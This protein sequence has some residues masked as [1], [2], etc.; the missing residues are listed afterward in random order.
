MPVTLFKDYSQSINE[1]VDPR[2]LKTN[3]KNMSVGQLAR[4]FKSR[5]YKFYGYIET[6]RRSNG[7]DYIGLSSAIPADIMEL[8]KKYYGTF[9]NIV[10]DTYLSSVPDLY[11]LHTN[12]YGGDVESKDIKDLIHDNTKREKVT[13]ATNKDAS[14]K[15]FVLFNTEEKYFYFMSG[16]KYDSGHCAWV[17]L[18]VRVRRDGVDE[19]RKELEA[20][21]D[22]VEAVLAPEREAAEEKSRQEREKARLK[23]IA[24]KE[25]EA[26][27]EDLKKY[28]E[29]HADEFKQIKSERD[30]PAGFEI[31]ARYDEVDWST[32][33]P[34]DRCDGVV[35]V[36]D[37]DY[38]HCYKYDT[39]FNFARPNT[40]WGD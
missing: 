37:A 9:R 2:K 12:I 20:R 29:T 21:R 25:Q 16:C 10:K 17:D 26:R 8:A 30:L 35:Y 13:I 40:Y 32:K 23:E 19:V 27:N 36:C 31:F 22:A 4:E 38:K 11:Q 39:T 33:T 3:E 34:Y 24:K 28:V 14:K 1:S 18:Y 5:G 7:W 6:E 15:F